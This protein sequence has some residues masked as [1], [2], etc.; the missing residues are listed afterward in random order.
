MNYQAL[1][2]YSFTMMY[3]DIRGAL[4]ASRIAER[5]RRAARPPP[6]RRSSIQSASGTGLGENGN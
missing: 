1:T 3:E 5:A 6:I 2:N 4:P